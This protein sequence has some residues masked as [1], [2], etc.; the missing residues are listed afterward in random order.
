MHDPLLGG[1]EDR[2]Q[3]RLHAARRDVDDEALD[4]PCAHRLEVMGYFVDVPVIDVSGVWYDLRPR[5][6][7]ELHQRAAHT[8]LALG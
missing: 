4:L 6:L 1:P 5:H 8:N 7:H 3:K 2:H